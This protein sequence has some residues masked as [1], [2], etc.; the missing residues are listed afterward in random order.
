MDCVSET[1][2]VAPEPSVTSEEPSD[3]R[4][5]GLFGEGE[6]PQPKTKMASAAEVFDRFW[7]AYP[8]K[9]GKTAAQKNFT[10]AVKDGADP[11]AI[12]AAAARYALSRIGEDP[13]Y[14]KWA[15]GWLSERRWETEQSECDADPEGAAYRERMRVIRENAER[16]RAAAERGAQ[17]YDSSRPR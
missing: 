7:K 6:L 4:E 1:Q 8:K 10:K 16:F 11:E 15:Q 13:K 12:I 2:L 5:V 17:N 14:T 9:E 3:T